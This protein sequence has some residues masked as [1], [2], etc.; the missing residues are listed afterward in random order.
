MERNQLKT[1]A[2]KLLSKQEYLRFKTALKSFEK[3]GRVLDFCIDLLEMVNTPEKTEIL[4]EARKM[5][6]KSKQSEFSKI[7]RDL[8]NERWTMSA[9]M[10]LHYGVDQCKENNDGL[11]SPA[12]RARQ[13]DY[14]LL[15]NALKTGISDR[16]YPKKPLTLQQLQVDKKEKHSYE[17]RRPPPVPYQDG[18]VLFTGE[19]PTMQ[20]ILQAKEFENCKNPKVLR[21]E[22]ESKMV[23]FGFKIL[24]DLFTEREIVVK[25]VDPD[26]IAEKS[27]L[28]HRD[29]ITR[30]NNIDCE[31]ARKSDIVSL[32]KS[33]NKLKLTVVSDGYFKEAQDIRVKESAVAMVT[34][35]V[36]GHDTKKVTVYAD[37]DGWMGCSIRG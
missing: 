37:E 11:P 14:K 29:R 20:D 35:A 25:Q 18:N 26:S 15:G 32:I 33:E 34:S 10:S 5:L 6:P 36:H 4:V 2:K 16:Q 8:V 27:G 12:K 21:M 7:C 13:G 19:T 1:F 22:R 9:K 28:K 31:R 17:R 3:K 30:I 24:G 23:N